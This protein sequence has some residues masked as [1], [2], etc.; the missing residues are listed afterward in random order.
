MNL[1][2]GNLQY[3]QVWLNRGTNESSTCADLLLSPL[4]DRVTYVIRW[5]GFI[6]RT[7][8]VADSRPRR[9]ALST[10]SQNIADNIIHAWRDDL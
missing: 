9:V 1:M 8:Q 5:G 10:G 2:R 7:I 6:N 3:L 4:Y